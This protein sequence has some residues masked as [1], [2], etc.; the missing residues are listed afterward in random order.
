MWIAQS[1]LPFDR[2]D[3]FDLSDPLF[4][5]GASRLF[6]AS[7]TLLEEGGLGFSVLCLLPDP[8]DDFSKASA[9]LIT[10]E[11][12]TSLLCDLFDDSRV[13]FDRKLVFDCTER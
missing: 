1:L 2:Q 5:P 3:L 13:D 9:A 10:L 12:E 8:C 6:A 4:S 7:L 11:R